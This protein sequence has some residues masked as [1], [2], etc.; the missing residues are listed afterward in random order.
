MA[1]IKNDISGESYKKFI[2]YM[3]SNSK[4]L[5]FTI[6]TYDYLYHDNENEEQ[7]KEYIKNI[8]KIMKKLN[9]YVLKTI[10]TPLNFL[11]LGIEYEREE[12][13][14][15]E[16]LYDI[17]LFEINKEVEAI[18]LEETKNL[19]SWRKPY[20]PE[21]LMF[22]K[23]DFIK[24]SITSHENYASVYCDSREEFK[25]VKEMGIEFYKEYNKQYEEKNKESSKKII[26]LLLK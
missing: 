18:L 4:I 22:I 23:D 20:L 10:N 24:F 12:W 26:Q 21:D 19:S 17:Y 1:D 11:L 25:K 9:P 5:C 14:N 13:E 16:Y 3:C 7:Y 8:E 6:T 2:K 15:E